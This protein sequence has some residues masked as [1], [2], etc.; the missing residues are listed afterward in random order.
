[1]TFLKSSCPDLIKDA[2]KSIRLRSTTYPMYAQNVFPEG[3]ALGC[4]EQCI[5]KISMSEAAE[6]HPFLAECWE[7]WRR[8]VLAASTFSSCCLGCSFNVAD[9]EIHILPF[10]LGLKFCKFQKIQLA[11]FKMRLQGFRVQ[12]SRTY[13]FNKGSFTGLYRMAFP[14][15]RQLIWCKLEMQKENQSQF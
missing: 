2:W 4:G 13:M 15:A 7:F 5:W 14:G 9:E 6:S 8:A 11:G 1:M 10:L 12:P 3:W